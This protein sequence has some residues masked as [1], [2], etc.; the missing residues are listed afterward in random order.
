L[1]KPI[2]I[3]GAGLAG[4]EAAWQI[5]QRGG[6]AALYEMKPLKK[7]SAHHQDTYAE[8]VCS[9]SLRSNKL[10]NA[11]GLLKEELRRMGSLIMECA[12]Q[13]AVPAGSALAVDRERFSICV[14]EKIRN[15]KNIEVFEQEVTQIDPE[16]ITIIATGPLTSENLYKH[17]SGI[18]GEK[19]LFFFDA[20]APIVEADS[21]NMQKAF[22]ASRYSQGDGDYINCPMNQEEYLAFHEALLHAETA[23]IKDFEKKLTFEG[24]MPIEV[25]AARGTDTLRFGPLKPVG[26]INPNT[27]TEPYAVVQLRQDNREGTLY[28][29]VGFQ[30]RLKWG[31]QKRV[32]SMIPGLENA[33]FVRYGVMHRNT[34]INSPKLLNNVYRLKKNENL[35]FAG[36]ITGVEG[37]VESTASGLVAGINAFKAANGD[38]DLVFPSTTAIGALAHYISSSS[39]GVFQPMN[40]NFGIISFG[41]TEFEQSGTTRLAYKDSALSRK[42]L[43]KRLIAQ[44]ALDIIDSLKD[45]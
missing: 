45:N 42:Q 1:T 41:G 35:Y 14:T 19:A 25:L 27:G 11:V 38:E 28:N 8:L 29:I 24:C 4:C 6:K 21:I 32:F 15:H 40:I 9:N 16:T 7:T 39:L 33:R 12:D 44:R 13:N 22:L 23:D 3:I 5:A 31:E 10:E 34:Y 37:Y 18:I 43:K 30:T 26:L 20:A 17:I 2:N 36:Q